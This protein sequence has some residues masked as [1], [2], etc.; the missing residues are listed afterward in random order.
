[1]FVL[2]KQFGFYQ[3]ELKSLVIS[4]PRILTTGKIL[5][6]KKKY[7]NFCD[8]QSLVSD[9]VHRDIAQEA[10]SYKIPYLL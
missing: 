6:L 10:H 2:N 8:T 1:M 5:V 7:C 9:V 4:H 3:E